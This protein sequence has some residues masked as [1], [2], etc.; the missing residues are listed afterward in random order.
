MGK[1]MRCQK[2]G[3][4]ETLTSAGADRSRILGRNPDKSLQSF[5]PC[6]FTVTCLR[7]VL[8]Q[9]HATSYSFYSSLL[10]TV[11]EK[12][13]KPETLSLK[14]L[15]IMPRNL[16]ANGTFMNLASDQ[17]LRNQLAS[18]LCEIMVLDSYL[19]L[20]FLGIIK[21]EEESLFFGR[22]LQDEEITIIHHF[23]LVHDNPVNKPQC[24]EM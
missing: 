11:K 13:G 23:D 18:I 6:P 10:Y 16:N 2:T 17:R 1:E 14:T 5:S 3:R 24:V 4:K 9:T 8:L 12:G 19:W 7:F 21:P 22:A 15:K 20:F